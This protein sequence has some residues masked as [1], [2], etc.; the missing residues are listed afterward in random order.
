MN[1]ADVVRLRRLLQQITTRRLRQ[2][3]VRGLWPHLLV[4]RQGET[5]AALSGG[6][7]QPAPDGGLRQVDGHHMGAEGHQNGER[8]HGGA[9]AEEHKGHVGEVHPLGRL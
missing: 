6:L 2:L 4:Q 3:L 8:P 5:P 7:D 1:Y 9:C